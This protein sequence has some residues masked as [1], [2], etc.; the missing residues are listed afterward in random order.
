MNSEPES[1]AQRDYLTP[2]ADKIDAFLTF[3]SYSQ[4]ILYPYSWKNPVPPHN[5][6]ELEDLGNKMKDAIKDV[7]G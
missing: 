5:A 1:Q 3:H 7:H 6:D 4:Y 2:M